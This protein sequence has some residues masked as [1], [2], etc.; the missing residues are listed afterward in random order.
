ML[1]DDLLPLNLVGLFFCFLK[2]LLSS[3]LLF[4]WPLTPIFL[5]FASRFSKSPTRFIT[6]R[7]LCFQNGMNCLWC[8]PGKVPPP[9]GLLATQLWGKR[10]HRE[11]ASPSDF[12]EL[13]T[14]HALYIFQH[15]QRLLKAKS[16]VL[17]SHG[18]IIKGGCRLGVLLGTFFFFYKI[19]AK[20]CWWI[21]PEIKRS[22]TQGFK[23]F[24]A[25]PQILEICPT[26]EKVMKR[27]PI[28]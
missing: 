20:L 3:D 8:W 27:V 17:S 6:Y 18:T 16:S 15:T 21:L 10:P 7:K 28:G 13:V 1:S 5:C 9:L 4:F 2:Q 24:T 11:K 26:I 12:N 19:V 23:H 14:W 25:V 22:F